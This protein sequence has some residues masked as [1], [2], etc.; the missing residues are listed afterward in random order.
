[1]VAAA[2]TRGVFSTSSKV[3]WDPEPSVVNDANLVVL[4]AALMPPPRRPAP[5][6]DL[7]LGEAFAAH[8]IEAEHVKIW[9]TVGKLRRR[10]GLVM[11]GEPRQ[12]RYLVENWFWEARRVRSTV[13]RPCV[14]Y[15]A[16][17]P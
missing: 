10:Q 11:S 5:R 13:R 1:L 6:R 7:Y 15:G 4:A 16:E 14:G 8:G 17:S 2:T 9:Q 3:S 12:P